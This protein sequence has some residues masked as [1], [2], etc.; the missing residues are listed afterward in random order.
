[1]VIFCVVV[2]KEIKQQEMSETENTDVT[3]GITADNKKQLNHRGAQLP[4]KDIHTGFTNTC[5]V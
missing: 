5:R 3:K 4:I 2:L 1:M